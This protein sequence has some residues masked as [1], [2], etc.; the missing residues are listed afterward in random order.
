MNLNQGKLN[1]DLIKES[2]T[3]KIKKFGNLQIE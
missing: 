1:I 3:M 2:L